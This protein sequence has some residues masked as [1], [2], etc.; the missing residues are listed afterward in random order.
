MV[1]K[2]LLT[3]L[4]G[5]YLFH[6]EVEEERLFNYTRTLPWK[7]KFWLWLDFFLF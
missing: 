5:A 1:V 3:G 6:S 2:V 7:S 4:I